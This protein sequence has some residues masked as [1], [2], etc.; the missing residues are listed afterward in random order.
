MDFDYE[1]RINEIRNHISNE[2]RIFYNLPDP[3]P[4]IIKPKKIKID[5]N[6]NTTSKEFRDMEYKNKMKN[7]NKKKIS[8]PKIINSSFEDLDSFLD[9]KDNLEKLPWN[10]LGNKI[11][12]DKINKFISKQDWNDSDKNIV[13]KLLK[14]QLS[15]NLLNKK[16][17]VN[18][19]L[20]DFEIIEIKKLKVSL[21]KQGNHTFK[22]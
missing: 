4:E 5:K 13:L 18:Y 2:N 21:D 15:L 7:K 10:K 14:N 22:I 16:S 8:Q 6:L 17:D 20:E 11:K 9:N 3:E 12:L 1:K 19:S